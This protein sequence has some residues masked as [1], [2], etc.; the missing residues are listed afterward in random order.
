MPELDDSD[1]DCDSLDAEVPSHCSVV[2]EG[3]SPGVGTSVP[4]GA[5]DDLP[6]LDD[7]DHESAEEE[8]V[9]VRKRPGPAPRPDS[10]VSG[11]T[12]SNRR[13]LLRRAMEQQ[14]NAALAPERKRPGPTPLPDNKVSPKTQSNRRSA[15]RAA[16]KTL[17]SDS[18]SLAPK[19]K[20]P[21][22][23]PKPMSDV[24]PKTRWNRRSAMRKAVKGIPGGLEYVVLLHYSKRQRGL[25]RRRV[26]AMR[27]PSR[28]VLFNILVARQDSFDTWASLRAARGAYGLYRSAA[29]A[30]EKEIALEMG[31][32]IAT[33]PQGAFVD[34]SVAISDLPA[35]L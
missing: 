1:S 7:F 24:T 18:R 16:L 3:P 4:P 28:E 13:S 2:E 14:G 29:T 9:P 6:D 12:Q 20:R 22:R 8:V 30:L 34:P 31:L 25:V 11:K 21:G 19:R 33:S 10:E 15:V 5:A 17:A 23:V 32:S 35:A 26:R 27:R